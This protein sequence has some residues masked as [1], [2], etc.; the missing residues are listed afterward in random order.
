MASLLRQIVAGPRA[1]HPEAG[2]DLC[3]V[4]DF[5]IA[6]SGPSQT[7]PQLA[8][9]NPLDQL[10]AFLDAKHGDNWAIWEFRAEGTGYPDEAVYGR[11]RH[12]P[13]PDHHPPPFRLVPMIMASM[14]NWLHGGDLLES[15]HTPQGSPESPHP[16]DT[17][18]SSTT[19]ADSF[20]A[21]EATEPPQ[22]PEAARST[23]TRD[24]KRV[25]VVHCK[26]GKGRSGTMATSY[27]VSEEGWTAE[28][29]LARFTARRMRP[30]FGAG[31]SIP[32]Q[33]RW[34]G[35]VDRWTK[36][37]KK[38]LD[39]PIEIVEIHVWGLRNG[40]KMDVQGFAEDGKKIKVLHTFSK[41]ERHVVQAG[42]PKETGIGE[43]LWDLAGYGLSATGSGNKAPKEVELADASNLEDDKNGASTAASLSLSSSS[44]QQQ[45]Q[46][47]NGVAKKMQTSRS[48]A[49]KKRHVLIR[50]GTGLIQKVS[51]NGADV[52]EKVK[53]KTSNSTVTTTNTTTSNTASTT[54]TT[55]TTTTTT[56][57]RQDQN[58]TTELNASSSSEDPEPGGMAVILK[59]AQPIQVPTSDV[60]IGVERRNKTHKSLS[61][62]AMVSA[63]AHVWFNAFFEGQ[64]PEQGGR[65]CESGI[66]SIDWDAMDGIKGSSRKGSRALDRMSVV[67]RAVGHGES[68][69]TSGEEMILEPAEGEPVPQ[70]AAADWKGVAE[71]EE[72]QLGL[73]VQT[74]G[75]KDVSS[76]SSLSGANVTANGDDDDDD[77]DDDKVME[78]VKASGPTGED[79]V[80]GDKKQ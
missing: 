75:S 61:S 34:V 68:T 46:Q 29:A 71:E 64:G 22:S 28:D 19:P 63:V 62:L 59:P 60:N 45:Q 30:K 49:E 12:Y 79:L 80:K 4:T 73:R 43:M 31:V 8:Y 21:T 57:Q 38:Y 17:L 41:R 14:R 6:T 78:G 52:V 74:E 37:G 36:H 44:E 18:V 3:Y 53:S 65:P 42:V 48:P 47:Q 23:T 32:S 67:W 58:Q 26:A 76:A 16:Q 54:T 40:V 24:E 9:R 10:V 2:L 20:G 13:W 51:A 33:L 1:R 27:L 77:D 11:V 5:I 70:V 7:Y 69:S 66:F 55:A 56:T 25:V 39:R 72:T 35:Y 50:K 15:K